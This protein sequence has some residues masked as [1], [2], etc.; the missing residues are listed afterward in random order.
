MR[1]IKTKKKRG[2][3]L[4]RLAILFF[5][6]YIAVSLVSQ[7]I[8]INE[9]RRQLQEI[10]QQI[11]VQEIKNEEIKHALSDDDQVNEDYIEQMARENLDYAK[12]GERV[13][14]NIAGN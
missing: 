4:L 12:P 2:S 7:Q 3:F 6:G 11:V 10:E 9:K 13:F 1:V 5:A 14:V 8:Q